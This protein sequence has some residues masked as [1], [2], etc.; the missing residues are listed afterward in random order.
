VAQY[1]RALRAA[2]SATSCAG[3]GAA[4][5]SN[6]G[7]AARFLGLYAESE[8]ALRKA[9]ALDPAN[10]PARV[11]LGLLLK[12]LGRVDEAIAQFES[13]IADDPDDEE[14]RWNLALVRLA[15]GDFRA[16]WGDYEK[17]WMQRD[18]LKRRFDFPAWSGAAPAGKTVLVFAE[19][20][21]GDEIMFASCIPDAVR[22]G[23][24]WVLEC[25]PRLHALFQR[26]FAQVEVLPSPLD[27][28]ADWRKRLRHVD[29]QVPVGSLPRLLG[30]DAGTFPGHEGYLRPEPSRVAAWKGALTS[31]G[32]GLKVGICWRGGDPRTGRRTRSLE[33]EQLAPLLRLKGCQ[34]VSLQH[35]EA[36]AECE[37]VPRELGVALAHW[38]EAQAD[39]DQAAAL[40]AALDLVVTVTTAAVHLAGALGKRAWVLVPVSPEWRYGLGGERMPWYPSVR[41]FR[42]V[43]PLDWQPVIQR[44]VGELQALAGA[45]DSRG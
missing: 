16:G 6:L 22:M 21:L 20:G 26:S 31:L 13:V 2:R 27:A 43:A 33:L 8:R 40:V 44:I 38:P 4:S 24:R 41:L 11:N 25:S 14:V 17:R 45:P 9:L 35:G 28:T 29:L 10:H 5:F 32:P 19:Q 15:S 30:R 1:D 23:G 39:F 36:E 7:L 18:A 3:A 12:D 37:A 34:F 42:Q